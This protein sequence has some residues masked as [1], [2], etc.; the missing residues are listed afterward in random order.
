MNINN[1]TEDAQ[2]LRLLL[3]DMP[4][5]TPDSLAAFGGWMLAKMKELDKRSGSGGQVWARPSQIAER[6]GVKRAQVAS[7]LSRL[8]E[9]GKVRRWQPETARGT[10]GETYYNLEDLEKAWTIKSVN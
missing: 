9:A 3:G 8:V 4:V 6:F 1:L 7:W 10:A 2:A 5:I